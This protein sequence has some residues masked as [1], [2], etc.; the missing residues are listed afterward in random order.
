MTCEEFLH[1]LDTR[2]APAPP[3]EAAWGEHAKSCP[4]CSLALRMERSLLAAPSWAA[5]PT[6]SPD[7]RARVL[8]KAR[9]ASLFLPSPLRLL[10]DSVIPALLAAS[11][12]AA[13]VTLFPW[14][15]LDFLPAELRDWILPSLVPFLRAWETGLAYFAPLASHPLGAGLLLAAAFTACLAAMVSLRVL[16][17]GRLA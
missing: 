8:A 10:S 16:S 13:I 7:R 3:V 9:G 11:F 12:L 4:S 14:K 15:A 6:L 17:P 5:M 2:T 1:L